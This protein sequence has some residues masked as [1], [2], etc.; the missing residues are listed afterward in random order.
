MTD[1]LGPGEMLGDGLADVFEPF[2]MAATGLAADRQDDDAA[3][4]LGGR[5]RVDVRF[6]DAP[7]TSVGSH[8]RASVEILVHLPPPLARRATE[9]VCRRAATLIDQAACGDG[10]HVRRLRVAADPAR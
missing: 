1:D 5:T 2:L 3:A 9:D 6:S 10:Y 8:A 4:L 7:I